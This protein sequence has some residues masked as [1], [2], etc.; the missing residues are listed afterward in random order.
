MLFGS[1]PEDVALDPNGNL[2]VTS[3]ATRHTEKA[4]FTIGGTLVEI[5]SGGTQTA[6]HLFTARKDGNLP[7]TPVLV[8]PGVGGKFILYG[9]TQYITTSN[10]G[11]MGPGL[12]FQYTP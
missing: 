7:Y 5:S 9:S 8:E 6:L 12:I 3:I 4:V 10:R 11:P 1:Y 2:Y